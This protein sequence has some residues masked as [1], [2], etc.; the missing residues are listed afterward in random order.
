MSMIVCEN[1]LDVAGRKQKGTAESLTYNF[2]QIQK[3]THQLIG[4]Y[5]S[6]D[7]C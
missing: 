5:V 6:F 2:T 7:Y 3:L 4:K 1:L